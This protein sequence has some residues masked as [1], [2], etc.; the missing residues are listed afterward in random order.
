V[1]EG[2]LKITSLKRYAPT[3]THNVPLATAPYSPY[4]DAPWP[5]TWEVYEAA[6]TRPPVQ[7]SPMPCSPVFAGSLYP[8]DL[9]DAEWAQLA[10][11]LPGPA[12]RGRPRAWPLR[13]L[14]NAL[15]YVLRTGCAWRYLPREYPPWQTA[16]TTLRQW[17]LHGVWQCV[18]EAWRRAVRLRAG[19]HADPSAAIMDSQSVK[20][21]EE[22]G[23]IKGYEGGKQDK[24][25]K[26]HLLVDTLGLL[27]SVYVTPA[28]T[29]DQ[30]GARRLL[31]GLK[32]LQPRLELIWA[33]GS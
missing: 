13:L 1:S 11:L 12:R 15:F 31:S 32:P 33:D 4:Y 14:V 17:R 27:L 18:H 19:R 6:H 24:G 16:S 5:C 8:C 28:N 3:I 26:R 2:V 25:R 7:R 10:P 21:T 22:S 29:S 20:T 9:T 23:G 30:V